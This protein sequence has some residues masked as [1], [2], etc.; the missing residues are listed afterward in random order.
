MDVGL[1]GQLKR[2][3]KIDFTDMQSSTKRYSAKKIKALAMVQTGIYLMIGQIAAERN[4][5]PAPRHP[6]SQGCSTCGVSLQ[7]L[8]F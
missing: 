5:G 3:T 7:G 1:S 4:R 8:I 6:K 2:K